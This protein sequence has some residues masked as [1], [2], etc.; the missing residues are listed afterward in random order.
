[1]NKR[2]RFDHELRVRIETA[3]H[4][5]VKIVCAD[6]GV[7]LSFVIRAFVDHVNKADGTQFPLTFGSASS[8]VQDPA[9]PQLGAQGVA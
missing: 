1:M 5:R 2:K 8:V 4:E 3:A 6:A 7:N 9:D